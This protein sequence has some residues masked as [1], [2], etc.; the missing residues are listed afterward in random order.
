MQGC[1]HDGKSIWGGWSPGPSLV[2]TRDA[3]IGVASLT[4]YRCRNCNRKIA[5]SI[6][7]NRLYSFIALGLMMLAVMFLMS[8]PWGGWVFVVVVVVVIIIIIAIPAWPIYG[9]VWLGRKKREW[10]YNRPENRFDCLTSS[11]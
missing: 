9:H 4:E 6:M 5:V 2:Q 11:E 1:N 3:D 7:H 8:G 10:S